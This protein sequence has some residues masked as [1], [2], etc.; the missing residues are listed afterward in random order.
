MAG[1]LEPVDDARSLS[2]SIFDGLDRFIDR[3]GQLVGVDTGPTPET[4][5]ATVVSSPA[6]TGPTISA[7]REQLAL[8]AVAG[9]ADHSTALAIPGRSRRSSGIPA[10]AITE[11]RR[12]GTFVVSNGVALPTECP[13]RAFAV[14]LRDTLNKAIG[15]VP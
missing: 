7:G 10:F 9:E 13:T 5:R 1:F 11:D 2:D 6:P 8:P 14:E 3:A 12:R 15:A 4:I